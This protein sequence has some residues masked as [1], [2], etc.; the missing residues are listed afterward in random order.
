MYKGCLAFG[1]ALT[2]QGTTYVCSMVFG[3]ITYKVGNCLLLQEH[4]RHNPVQQLLP[5]QPYHGISSVSLVV[6]VYVLACNY[7]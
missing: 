6:Y 1:P 5:N 4:P 3:I 2:Y 7:G